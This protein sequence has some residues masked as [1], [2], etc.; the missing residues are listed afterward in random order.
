M[1]D[2]ETRYASDDSD[3]FEFKRT[4]DDTKIQLRKILG[5]FSYLANE[6]EYLNKELLI[7]EG[8]FFLFTTELME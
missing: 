3:K 8:E 6:G 7:G 2:E 4:W 5:G 1:V